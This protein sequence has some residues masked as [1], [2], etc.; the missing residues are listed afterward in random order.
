MIPVV[1]NLESL[2][3]RWTGSLVAVLGICLGVVIGMGLMRLIGE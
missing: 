3:E 2:R 1:Y